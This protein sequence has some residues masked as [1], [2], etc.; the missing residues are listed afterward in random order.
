MSGTYPDALPT[1]VDGSLGRVKSDA[2]AVSDLDYETP[3]AEFNILADSVEG[4]C[5]TFG[6][7]NA[8]GV[9]S[10]L[11]TAI[12]SGFVTN[13]TTYSA[14][15]ALTAASSLWLVDGPYD[16]VLPDDASTSV[17][18]LCAPGGCSL[19][20]F[21][22]PTTGTINGGAAG[23]DAIFDP[24]VYFVVGDGSDGWAVVSYTLSAVQLTGH[25]A[26]SI[27]ARSAN[28]TG[29]AA[30]LAIGT[31]EGVFNVAGVL[32]SRK[33]QT[34][35]IADN[36]VTLAKLATQATRTVLANITGSTAVPT[37]TALTSAHMHGLDGLLSKSASFTVGAT[38][39]AFNVDT[40]AGAVNVTF[41][42]PALFVGRGVFLHKT[43][44][45]ANAITPVS[46]ASETFNGAAAAAFPGS[47]LA[48]RLSW[49][50]YSDGTN[51][52]Y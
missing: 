35:N 26:H 15:G 5:A 41:P 38:E 11:A 12:S 13:F 18:T 33:A 21:G 6:L 20:P 23:A 36:A 28:S 14:D 30:D 32:T 37:A 24:G 51:W 4:L 8:N 49:H 19:R 1:R 39:W 45:D 3:A 47:T 34:A 40:S 31:D 25:S 50:V 29:N 42:D 27:V 16:M 44:A 7:P 46:Y 17:R 48:S 43:T 52:H 9:P 22:Y 2:R 10:L